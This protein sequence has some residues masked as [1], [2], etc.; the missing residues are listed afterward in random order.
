M[1]KIVLS[2]FLGGILLSNEPIGSI[3]I[4]ERNGLDRFDEYI[5]ILIPEHYSDSN[6]IYVAANRT[7]HDTTIC[8]L[9]KYVDIYSNIYNNTLVFPVDIKANDSLSYD[10]VIFNDKYQKQSHVKSISSLNLSGQKTELVIENEYYIADLRADSTEEEKSY[11]SG[12]IRDLTIKLGFD[13][14]LTNRDDRIHWAPNFKRPELQY[15]KTIAHWNDPKENLISEGDYLVR[16]WR[17]DNAPSHPEIMLSAE[18]SFYN[19]KPYFL[20]NSKMEMIDNVILELLRNDEMTMDTMFTHLAFKRESGEIIDIPIEER[21]ILLENQP[22]SVNDPWIC[23]Y[24]KDKGYA[25]GSIRLDY[26]ITNKEGNLSPTGKSYTSIAQWENRTTYWNRRIIYN[27][28]VN[29]L[30]GSR[31]I[32][33]NAYIMFDINKDDHL[34]DIKYWSERLLNPIIVETTFIN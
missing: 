34:S 9:T 27:E 21:D 23:F 29:V 10:L 6:A 18:Y 26:N 22:I 17:K 28:L 3:K 7:S 13:Q 8:Q 11:Q 4:Y 12:Q 20:F 16:T 33:K 25:F 15:Y 32:E 31:Y 24:N 5:E 19:N 30:K 14:L 1:N 2:I